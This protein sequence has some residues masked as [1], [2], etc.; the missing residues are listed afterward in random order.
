[1]CCPQNFGLRSSRSYKQVFDKNLVSRKD[2]SDNPTYGAVENFSN[3]HM[4]MY[5]R[6]YITA[7]AMRLIIC[8]YNRCRISVTMKASMS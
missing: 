6:M 7:V 3:T 5:V 1:M 8:L 4:H 2:F